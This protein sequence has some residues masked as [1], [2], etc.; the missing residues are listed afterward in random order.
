MLC[1][2]LW[3][4]T[5]LEHVQLEVAGRAADADRDVVPHHLRAHHRQR[6]RLRRVHLA[7]HDRAAGLVL[8]NRDLAQ[9]RARARR[10]ASGRRSRSSSARWPAF[11]A[12]PCSATS[13]SCPASAANLFGARHERQPR[14]LRDLLG[15]ALRVLR[16]RVEAGADG[17]AAERQLVDRRQRALRP[18]AS[19]RRAARPSRRSPGRA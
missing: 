5:R 15:A 8:G 12:P 17:R 6:F 7:G 18:R 3:M 2:T 11:S 13:A 14:E 10:R 4:M 1:S 16:M 19:R 9:A